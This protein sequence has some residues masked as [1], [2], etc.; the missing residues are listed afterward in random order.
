[1]TYRFVPATNY[2]YS[3]LEIDIYIDFVTDLLM[4]EDYTTITTIVDSF[5]DKHHFFPLAKTDAQS[6]A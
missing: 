3:T 4:N 1:M 2:S 5:S 6:M